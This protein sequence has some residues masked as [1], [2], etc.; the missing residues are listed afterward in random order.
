MS[1]GDLSEKT[2]LP[3]KAPETGNWRSFFPGKMNIHQSCPHPSDQGDPG[4]GETRSQITRLAVRCLA[5][6]GRASLPS[7]ERRPCLMPASAK[8]WN[9]VICMHYRRYGYAGRCVQT[10]WVDGKNQNW[11][12]PALG[13]PVDSRRNTWF[14]LFCCRGLK[15][16]C[17]QPQ[18]TLS[19]ISLSCFVCQNYL[20]A[21]ILSSQGGFRL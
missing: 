10:P 11:Y 14:H 19:S 15:I 21:L 4:R 5:A 17:I 2:F 6:E 20:C 18:S 8:P 9:T 1:P 12:F 16:W 7:G 13:Y 3:S